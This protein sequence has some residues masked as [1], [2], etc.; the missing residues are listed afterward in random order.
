MSIGYWIL[1]GVG[2]FSF[3]LI[4]SAIWPTL[5]EIIMDILSEVVDNLGDD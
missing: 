4:I 1:A 2:A 5:G 3:L